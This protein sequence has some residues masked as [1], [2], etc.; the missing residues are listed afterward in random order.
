MVA[1]RVAV[2]VGVGDLGSTAAIIGGAYKT[3]TT[4]QAKMQP[5]TV[6]AMRAS[7]NCRTIGFSGVT[8]ADYNTGEP[9]CQFAPCK[10]EICT[11]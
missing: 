9:M 10:S 5:S 4:M 11:H 7:I 6:P 8:N 2:F 3:V 1:G